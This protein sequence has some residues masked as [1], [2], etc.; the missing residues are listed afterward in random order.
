MQESPSDVFDDFLSEVTGL[1]H[2]GANSGQERDIYAAKGLSVL[3]IE[4][5]LDVFADLE[6]NIAGLPKQGSGARPSH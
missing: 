1:I 3:W 4:A 5:L 6:T 2:V